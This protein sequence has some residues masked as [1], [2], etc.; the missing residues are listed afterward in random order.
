MIINMTGGGSAGGAGL[1]AIYVTYPAGSVCTVTNGEKTFTAKDSSGFW[2]F[3]GLSV[4]TWTVTATDGTETDSQTVEI[5][6]EGQSV[7]VELIY[8]LWLYDY[9]TQKFGTQFTAVAKKFN[10]GSN[11]VQA[12]NVSTLADGSIQLQITNNNGC[13][14]WYSEAVDLTDYTTLYVLDSTSGTANDARTD[15]AIWS[16]VGTYIWENVK[17][18]IET[19]NRSEEMRTIDVSALNGVHYI[20]YAMFNKATI[21]MKQMVLKRG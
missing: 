19:R 13:G 20:G 2:L 21:N 11:T 4:G 3:A 7:S 14:M 10:S 1:P 18:N 17:A 5:T 12:P 15:I 16:G 9:K 6:T 8:G